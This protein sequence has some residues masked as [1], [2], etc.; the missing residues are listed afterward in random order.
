MPLKIFRL[1]T[2]VILFIFALTLRT[3]EETRQGVNI[4]VTIPNEAFRRSFVVNLS[5][6]ERIHLTGTEDVL[7]ENNAKVPLKA[8]QAN[9]RKRVL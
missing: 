9:R 8:H 5:P 4:D 2:L 1:P 3:F 6:G 7:G